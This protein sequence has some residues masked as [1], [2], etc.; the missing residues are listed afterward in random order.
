MITIR[1]FRTIL[2]LQA[3]SVIML[4]ISMIAFRHTLPPEIIAFK[5]AEALQ[6]FNNTRTY[7]LSLYG[8]NL[9]LGVANIVDFIGLYLLKA[10]ARPLFIIL[11]ILSLIGPMFGGI[12]ILPKEAYFLESITTTLSGIILALLYWSPIREI[13]DTHKNTP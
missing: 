11:I 6:C 12:S 7:Y 5:H 13:F 2:L 4:I 9:L 8:F 3:T 1:T 10:F